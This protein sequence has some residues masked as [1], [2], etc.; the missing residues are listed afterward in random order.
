MDKISPQE[1]SRVMKAVG[2]QNT[3]PE[4][5]VRRLL[6]R[7]GYRYR[8]HDNR[9]PGTPDIVFKSRKKVIFVHGCFWHGHDCRRSLQPKSRTDYWRDKI[10]RNRDRDAKNEKALRT[11]GWDVFSVWECSTKPAAIAALA[12]ALI[13]FLDPALEDCEARHGGRRMTEDSGDKSSVLPALTRPQRTALL[14]FSPGQP[15]GAFPDVNPRTAAALWSSGLLS[16]E[17]SDGKYVYVL[18]PEGEKVRSRLM[19]EL[20]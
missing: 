3:A 13:E 20:A 16:G 19:A 14:L 2:R 15:R 10:A 11:L 8:T 4:M 9:L 12:E 1:R 6:H 5:R 17:I 7:L 18:T